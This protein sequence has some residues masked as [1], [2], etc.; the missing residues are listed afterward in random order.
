DRRVRD[1]DAVAV[2]EH[3]VP[4]DDVVAAGAQPDP[5]AEQRDPAVLD[6]RADRAVEVDAVPGARPIAAGDR[7]TGAIEHDSRTE[8]EPDAGADPEIAIE[9]RRLDD[10]VAALTR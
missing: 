3:L 8:L 5:A 10:G 7:V 2:P 4:G 6:D 9:R 1:V